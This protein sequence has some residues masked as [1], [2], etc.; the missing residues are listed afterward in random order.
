MIMTFDMTSGPK[1]T[2][3][4]KWSLFSDERS[5]VGLLLGIMSFD[6]DVLGLLWRLSALEIDLLC[7]DNGETSL[8]VY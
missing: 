8:C 3:T 2:K 6:K 5:W 7:E 4:F 1:S